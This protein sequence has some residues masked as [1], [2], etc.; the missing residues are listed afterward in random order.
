MED[1]LKSE[2]ASCSNSRTKSN[3]SCA[4]LLSFCLV[5]PVFLGTLV[6]CDVR[7]FTQDRTLRFYS[8]FS[9]GSSSMQGKRC[10][11]G[12]RAALLLSFFRLVNGG[13]RNMCHL[14]SGNWNNGIALSC[15]RSECTKK[16]IFKLILF[17]T[18]YPIVY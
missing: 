10:K 11:L 6:C 16:F 8:S 18:Y 13:Q 4:P 2:A 1:V 7:V 15:I 12:K 3:P 5:V 17:F 14:P 9:G